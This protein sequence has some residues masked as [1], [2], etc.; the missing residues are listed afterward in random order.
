MSNPFYFT[1]LGFERVTL[2]QA[3]DMYASWII[4]TNPAEKSKRRSEGVLPAWDYKRIL[5]GGDFH[6]DNDCFVQVRATRDEVLFRFRHRQPSDPI[7]IWTTNV[8]LSSQDGAPGVRVQ[9]G[10]WVSGL[11]RGVQVDSVGAPR[12]IR[13]LFHI[14]KTG[15]SPRD[16][17]LPVTVVC[18]KDI[19][20]L[21]EFT[22]L[23]PGRA[24]PLV[25]V[26]PSESGDLLV[27]PEVLKKHLLGIASVATL[28]PFQSSLLLTDRLGSAGFPRSFGLSGGAVRCYMPKMRKD[29][30]PFAHPLWTKTRLLGIG[31][32]IQASS[33]YVAKQVYARSIPRS[34]PP[35]LYEHI[36]WFDRILQIN[37]IAARRREADESAKSKELIDLAFGENDKLTQEVKQ[38]QQRLADQNLEWQIQAEDWQEKIE[39]AEN[40]ASALQAA[41]ENR[42]TEGDGEYS[43]ALT[44]EE[45]GC[46]RLL[47]AG[48][49]YSLVDVLLAFKALYS[50]RL[51]V[52]DSAIRSARDSHDFSQPE[53]AHELVG[54]FV[55]AYYEVLK[56]GRPEGEAKMVL[57]SKYAATE[58]EVMGKR[59]EDLRTFTYR[60]ERVTMLRHLKIGVGEQ[61]SNCL[62]IH[63]HWDS[64]RSLLVV[65][66]CGKH[67]DFK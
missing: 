31:S 19:D 64:Q 49:R 35:D 4:G 12:I 9:H 50:D 13:E 63:F 43:G 24:L 37:Q 33:D 52:L 1:E 32:S 54:K 39:Q 47:I 10:N 20:G 65:G 14:S 53:A 18:E 7:K 29:E 15:I 27:D 51:V 3:A 16:A 41:F 44:A 61:T 38:L 5:L 30:S 23:D 48:Q 11:P 55:T 66:H 58:S 2:V 34:V 25:V 36:E 57:G 28:N 59:G 60:G 45:S 6:G 8:R 40:K 26:S 46:I 62:R 21:I 42:G 17:V 67:L 22:L 56:S